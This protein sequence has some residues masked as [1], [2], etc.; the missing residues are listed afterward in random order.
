MLEEDPYVPGM[1]EVV[2]RFTSGMVPIR[3]DVFILE[4]PEPF[5][6]YPPADTFPSTFRYS[7]LPTTMI[8]DCTEFVTTR[9]AG[10][11]PV[12][13]VPLMLVRLYPL[14]EN[15]PAVTVFVT[16]RELRVPK[17]VIFD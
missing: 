12:T 8:L 5:P 11:I 2:G 17:L 1:T 16:A 7:K 9:A 4:I 3:F 13:F 10:T 15:I 14:P 6:K